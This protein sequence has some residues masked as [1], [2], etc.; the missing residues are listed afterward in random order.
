MSPRLGLRHAMCQHFNDKKK[1]CPHILVIKLVANDHA[2]QAY[3]T[4]NFCSKII[5]DHAMLFRQ[6]VGVITPLGYCC[7]N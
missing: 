3:A 7:F 5:S 2:T 4:I 1:M 6:N